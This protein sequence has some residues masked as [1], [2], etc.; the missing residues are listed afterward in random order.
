M[1]IDNERLGTPYPPAPPTVPSRRR[2]AA[3]VLDWW[4]S[5]A[6]QVSATAITRFGHQVT[7][8][9]RSRGGH[10]PSTPVDSCET[11]TGLDSG[12]PRS[13]R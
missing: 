3:A 5:R 13:R 8:D 2:S 6:A 7:L 10:Q 9:G 4:I 11:P 12:D 1:A